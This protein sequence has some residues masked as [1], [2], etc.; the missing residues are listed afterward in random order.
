MQKMQK[1]N[2]KNRKTNKCEKHFKTHK[3]T[4]INLRKRNKRKTKIPK[5]KDQTKIQWQTF[6]I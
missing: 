1:M 3:A 5:Q 2:I 6:T 4:S